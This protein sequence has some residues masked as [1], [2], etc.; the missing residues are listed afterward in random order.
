MKN[1]RYVY[2]TLATG[3]RF[4]LLVSSDT[5]NVVRG[6]EVGPDGD[7]PNH[8]DQQR[9]IVQKRGITSMHDCVMNYSDARLERKL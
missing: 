6:L 7:P 5:R 8:H 2:I 9:H 4:Y 1:L 3:E